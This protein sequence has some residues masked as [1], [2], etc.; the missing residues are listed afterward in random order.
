M[1]NQ[2]CIFRGDKYYVYFLQELIAILGQMEVSSLK[3]IVG[4]R[5]SNLYDL[6]LCFYFDLRS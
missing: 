1:L 6:F 5:N 3:F 2:G 4:T